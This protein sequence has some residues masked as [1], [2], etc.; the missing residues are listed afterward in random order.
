MRKV[1]SYGLT[2]YGYDLRAAE[3]WRVFVP[4]HRN[5]VV[6]PKNFSPDAFMEATG[7]EVII[8]PNSFVLAR[9]VERFKMPPDVFGLV[10]GKSTY[11]RCG[12]VVNT[13][14]LQPGWQGYLTIEISNT[15]PLPSRVYAN[16]GIAS[17]LFFRG[18]TACGASYAGAFQNQ[19]ARIVLPNE[20][21]SS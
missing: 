14:P 7:E 13:T 18:S 11:A 1:V 10:I 20:T 21:T 2:S 17:V 6:D 5:V 19:P 3:E 15:T 16:E 8:P 9:S 4:S 12:V